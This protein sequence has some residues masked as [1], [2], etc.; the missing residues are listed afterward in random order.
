M[1]GQ[2]T[3]PW[4]CDEEGKPLDNHQIKLAIKDDVNLIINAGPGSGKTRVL[5][6][7]YLHLLMSHLNWDIESVVAITFTE[8]AAAEMKE[9]ISRVLMRTR[10]VA[11]LPEWRTRAAEIL[12]YLPEAPI[13]TIHSFCARLLRRFA[14]EA[15]LDPK[16]RILDELEAHTLRT[17]V[18]EQWLWQTLF[19]PSSPLS[20]DA[21]KV[22]EH[23][24]FD[25][26]AELLNDL[27][28]VRLI[29]E[30]R[31][32]KCE[33]VICRIGDLTEQEGA[34]ERCYSEVVKAY[35]KGKEQ[36]NALDYDDLLL[37]TWKLLRENESVRKQVR[38]RHKRILVDELQDTDRVQVE[39][40]S[41]ICGWDEK[42]S[43]GVL[44]FG[45]GDSQQSIYGFRNADVAVFNELWKQV[46]RKQNWWR[47]RLDKN[48]RSVP[49]IVA[50]TNYAF[51]R[52]FKVSEKADE[53]EQRVRTPLQKMQPSRNE[54]DN[55]TP[56]E[57]A[58][59]KVTGGASKWQRLMLEAEWIA[60][61]IVELH[62]EGTHYRDITILLR[63]LINAFVFEEALRR[64][65][66]PYHIIA[67]YGFFETLEARDLLNFLQVL[68]EPDDELALASWLKSPM[69]GVSDETLFAIFSQGGQSL[70]LKGEFQNITSERE[71]LSRAKNLLEE[72]KR[73]V[74]KVSLRE[75]LEW[76]IRETKYDAIVAAL[77]HGCQRLANLRKFI[78]MAQQLNENLKLNIRGLTRY[79]KALLE[80]E[81]RIGEPP[82]A[83]ATANA[84]QIMTI[85]AAKGLEFPVVIIPMLGDIKAPEGSKEMLVTTPDKGI[86]VRLYDEA[87][88]SLEREDERMK[89]LVAVE[90]VRKTR[91]RAESERL[92]FVA[93]TR[94][95]DRLILTGTQSGE[96]K[97]RSGW[98]S[99]L[100]LVA[101]TLQVPIGEKRAEPFRL[102][103]G[104][105]VWLKGEVI[106]ASKLGRKIEEARREI[107]E[108]AIV[109]EA[110]K[111]LCDP[112]TIPSLTPPNLDLPPL[113]PARVVLS[114][115][116]LME[117]KVRPVNMRPETGSSR[118]S[119]Q[120][121]G[122][123]VHHCLQRQLSSPTDEQIRW[124]A[125]TVGA[126]PEAAIEQ[127]GVL[128]KF[129]EN[130]MR[131]SAWQQASKAS[132]RWHELD[133][134][135][136]LEGEP[137]VEL[138]GRWD[139][140]AEG[141]EWLIVDFKT[142]KVTCLEDAKALIDKYYTVQAQAYA[143]G[144]HQV[145]AAKSVK[146]VFVFVNSD[147]PYELPLCFETREF[148]TAIQ[149]L[150]SM[151]LEFVGIS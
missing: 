18:C 116:D 83:G 99:W 11:D 33:P 43:T 78:R 135:F 3:A 124:V 17:K 101:D 127:A 113:K 42:E 91:E 138:I 46:E 115:T 88:N 70:F 146:V 69:V 29:I 139:L 107:E 150:R 84:V 96:P 81:V 7:H 98:G 44:F 130:A 40:L 36:I 145:F 71:K 89:R 41:L 20:R 76:I 134:R 104:I 6:A 117:R 21:R 106:D 28:N 19:D 131:S 59:F 66:I 5:V 30:Y 58:F 90:E 54:N 122:L 1:S 97:S 38:M 64:R 24:R 151:A 47:D 109:K 75:L 62:G 105:S 14:V 85:H 95:K 126:D 108:A 140:I 79:A 112:N 137:P 80:G 129:V 147:S 51:E 16:F 86:G 77:P 32:S 118:L 121:M 8:K 68:A 114:V 132:R 35:D 65:E 39:I 34:L 15:G 57:F 125:Q 12:E 50:L 92:L 23:W 128:R 45:V 25:K 142:D 2:R 87:G 102:H 52:I 61:R 48:Y 120:E 9:R 100:Q 93:W 10:Q 72:A 111:W 82:L 13:S 110:V 60:E 143:V 119:P 144:A 148:E 149:S 31:Q 136:W 26:A 37:R 63:E 141:E 133:F 73:K 27:L 74:D 67:G 53:V 123:I 94:A 56:I 4:L 22:V 49:P 55:P 103:N